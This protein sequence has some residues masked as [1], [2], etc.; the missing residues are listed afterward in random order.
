[1]DIRYYCAAHT[2]RSGSEV[3]IQLRCF[4]VNGDKNEELC[5]LPIPRQSLP[6][7]AT[8]QGFYHCE[9]RD[10]LVPC[11]CILEVSFSY[12][13]CSETQLVYVGQAPKLYV[14]AK[15][16]SELIRC[17][18]DVQPE[19]W[20]SSCGPNLNLSGSPSTELYIVLPQLFSSDRYSKVLL[21]DLKEEDWKISSATAFRKQPASQLQAVQARD[22]RGTVTPGNY[23]LY[24]FD[25]VLQ[26]WIMDGCIIKVPENNPGSFAVLFGHRQDSAE[27]SF[28]QHRVMER[29]VSCFCSFPALIFLLLSVVV[30]FLLVTSPSSLLTG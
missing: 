4:T 20:F 13:D 7:S 9:W 5:S 15:A 24:L 25:G 27:T 23:R 2:F 28:G 10:V 11:R 16:E 6:F 8:S 19:N 26:K 18:T 17:L 14:M 12:G 3:T 30:L 29:S 1:V 21:F 22:F